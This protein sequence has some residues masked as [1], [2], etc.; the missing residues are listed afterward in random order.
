MPSFRICD[1]DAEI[2]VNGT[3]VD[4]TVDV[5]VDIDVNEF[6]SECSDRDIIEIIDT[7]VEDG[8]LKNHGGLLKEGETFMEAEFFEQ[9]DGLKGAYM[10][11][12]NEDIE[13]IEK[14]YKKYC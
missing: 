11:I 10:Q 14:I 8:Y 9:C 3:P 6:L 4:I 2:E 12:S 1:V 7:L 13:L 5:D